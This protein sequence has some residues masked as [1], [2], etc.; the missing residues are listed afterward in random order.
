MESQKRE[1]GIFMNISYEETAWEAGLFLLGMARTGR[2]G[3][4]ERVWSALGLSAPPP[5]FPF[6]F[7]PYTPPP[8]SEPEGKRG[9]GQ[10]AC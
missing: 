1:T 5:P 3:R 7:L 2:W 10:P 6:P 9:K 4:R 8:W